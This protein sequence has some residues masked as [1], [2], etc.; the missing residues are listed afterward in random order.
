MDSSIAEA[1]MFEQKLRGKG[2]DGGIE[3]RSNLKMK[4]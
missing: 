1:T 2:K 3:N 4:K